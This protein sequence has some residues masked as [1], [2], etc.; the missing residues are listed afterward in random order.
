[1]AREAIEKLKYVFAPYTDVHRDTVRV[2]LDTLVRQ[3]YGGDP[4]DSRQRL[5][6]LLEKKWGKKEPTGTR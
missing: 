2:L 6:N 1:M 4:R 5:D 3:E